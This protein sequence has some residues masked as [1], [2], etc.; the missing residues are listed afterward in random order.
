MRKLI[1]LFF[2]LLSLLACNLTTTPPTPTARP[3]QATLAPGNSAAPTL[4]ASITPLPGFGGASPTQ[5]AGGS[6]PTPAGWVPYTI[7]G[8]DSLGALADATGVAVQDIVNA[9]CMADPD[10][11]YT[12]QT[13]YL[14]RSPISG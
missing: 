11:L 1:A 13:I 10:T 12:G 8:G 4:F 5:P 2:L 3:A 6:C 14:P 7:E 9:N